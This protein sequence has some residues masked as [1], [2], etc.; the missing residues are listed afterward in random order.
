MARIA[1]RGAEVYATNELS[2]SN[3]QQFYASCELLATG[4]ARSLASGAHGGL[5]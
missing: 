1:V 2:T 3:K 5:S 4:E